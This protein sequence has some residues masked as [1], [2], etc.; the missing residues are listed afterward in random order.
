[1]LINTERKNLNL[2][3]ATINDMVSTWIEQ[4]IIVP[5]TKPDAVKIV[6]VSVTPYISDFDVYNDKIKI[7]GKI[8]YFVIYKVAD[9][10]FSTRGLYVSHPY[11][12]V[13]NVPGVT[14]DMNITIEPSV[15]NIIHS[16]PNE[17][18]IAV[19]TEVIFKVV[20]KRGN[21]ISLV[22][23]FDT[24]DKIECKMCRERFNNMMCFKRSIIASKEDVV[25]PSD[26]EDL[27]EIL[28]VDANIIN[29]EYKESYNKIMTKGDIEVK[30]LYLAENKD[31]MVKSVKVTV[32]FSAMIELEN[33]N[34]KSKYDINYII[35]DFDI[36]I[37]NE[38][39]TT[40][41]ITV[42]YQIEAC[43]SMYEE[44]E[45]EYV[46]DFYSQA[47]DLKYDRTNFDVVTSTNKIMKNIDLKENISNI[48]S[49][50]AR[51]VDYSFDPSYINYEINS[52]MIKLSGNA[53]VTLFYI[54]LDSL[55]LESKVVDV[56]VNENINLDNVSQ[57]SKII[58]DIRDIN[59]NVTQNGTDVEV[60]ASFK[61]IAIIENVSSINVIDN[62]EENDME[63]VNLDSMNIYIVKKGDTLWS[64]AKK[65]KT[66]V[67]KI[68]QTNDNIVDENVIDVG[69]KIFIIR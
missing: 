59:I 11:T 60:R 30:I 33:I 20:A 32:P 49:S 35:K 36:R 1:M 37:N 67:D 13:I 41:T 62:L 50:N 69:Q 24:E 46:E 2:D 48:L 65:Y 34:D 23:K 27:F 17:R 4:D 28:K 54:N 26:A 56:L 39:T 52:N 42:E 43:I 51:L 9:E 38:I 21:N 15:K 25:L 7:D 58:P 47:H 45:V 44:D 6:S 68:L 29:T 19:K 5:D 55:E 22:N 14:K 40:K 3:S 57:N 10:K 18:K 64:I 8:N 16:L 61:L 31:N 63:V 53:K 66:S 12:Q